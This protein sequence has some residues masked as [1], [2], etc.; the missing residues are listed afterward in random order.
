MRLE[1]QNRMKMFVF[2]GCTLIPRTVNVFN[3]LAA[4]GER[5]D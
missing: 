1:T 3:Y 5:T 4:E 2:I